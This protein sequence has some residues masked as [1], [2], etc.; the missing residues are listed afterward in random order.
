MNTA[1]I[2]TTVAAISMGEKEAALYCGVSVHS[3][4]RWRV[5]GG[6]PIYRKISARVVYLRTDLDEFLAACIR[7]STSDPGPAVKTAQEGGQTASMRKLK[8]V[9]VPPAA[10]CSPLAAGRGEEEK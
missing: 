2:L 3:L 5:Y 8:A 7:R 4:R 10:G 6:G 1:N 9:K